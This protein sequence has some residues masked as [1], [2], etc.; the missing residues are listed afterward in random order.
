MAVTKDI[1][2][3]TGKYTDKSGAE[4]SR[5]HKIGVVMTTQNGGELIK[6]EAIPVGWDGFAYLNEPKPKS[7][8]PTDDPF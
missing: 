6:I 1:V 4:K 2:A 7:A 8:P 5:Y 3:I